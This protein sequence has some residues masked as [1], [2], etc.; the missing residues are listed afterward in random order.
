LS[1]RQLLLCL[2]DALDILILKV[3]K[4]TAAADVTP[5]FIS[6]IL[7]WAKQGPVVNLTPQCPHKMQHKPGFTGVSLS[8]NAYSCIWA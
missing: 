4:E 7:G 1:A 3:F 5:E 6:R 8:D 2:Y